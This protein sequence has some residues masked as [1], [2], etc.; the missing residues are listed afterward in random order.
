M[1]KI[2]RRKIWPEFFKPVDSGEKPFEVRN[3][4]RDEEH[5]QVGDTLQLE[6]WD[7]AT[8]QYTGKVLRRIISYVLEVGSTQWGHNTV[9]L[10]LS[11]VHPDR[12]R[13]P[14]LNEE[15]M[16]GDL[17]QL[18]IRAL[19]LPS[20]ATTFAI[21]GKV[22]ELKN[23]MDAR[24][25]AGLPKS[26]TIVVEKED[27]DFLTSLLEAPP[28][29]LEWIRK[30]PK[31]LFIDWPDNGNPKVVPDPDEHHPGFDP[32]GEG[33]AYQGEPT[34]NSPQDAFDAFLQD[35]PMRPIPGSGSALAAMVQEVREAA[36][37][38]EHLPIPPAFQKD[39]PTVSPTPRT[40]PAKPAVWP[41]P[42]PPTKQLPEPWNEESTA[43]ILALV[44]ERDRFRDLARQKTTEA[45]ENLVR[46]VQAERRH[47]DLL[48]DLGKMIEEARR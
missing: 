31:R 23:R 22:Q 26:G 29:D 41:N 35:Q 2:I 18:M 13:L 27:F 38:I 12:L 19:N 45:E 34:P 37:P 46:A 4:D 47:A 5:F 15:D 39:R 17:R 44:E 40:P 20:T 14:T 25:I 7:P 11:N 21:I 24:E 36:P 43:K 6:E 48:A 42:P 32:T 8:Q 10:G 28:R 9:V 33:S 3:D 30:V 16:E 1:Q